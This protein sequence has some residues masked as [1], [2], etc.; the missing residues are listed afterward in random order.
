M[1]TYFSALYN[2]F[3]VP[4]TKL[5]SSVPSWAKQEF[6]MKT[7]DPLHPVAGQV[8]SW[9]AREFCSNPKKF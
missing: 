8:P 9:A 3:F 5:E 2:Y 4:E 6:Q 7:K 1:N